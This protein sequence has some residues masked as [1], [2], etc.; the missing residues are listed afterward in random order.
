MADGSWNSK[1]Y[2]Q[3]VTHIATAVC[4]QHE[5][6]WQSSEIKPSL[7]RSR[8]LCGFSVR[9]ELTP[10]YPVFERTGTVGGDPVFG[11]RDKSQLTLPSTICVTMRSGSAIIL[12]GAWH[13]E[14]PSYSLHWQNK[15][16]IKRVVTYLIL[17]LKC[18]GLKS[19]AVSSHWTW[20][21]S[22]MNFSKEDHQSWAPS[23]HICGQRPVSFP[24]VFIPGIYLHFFTPLKRLIY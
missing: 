6:I 12:C 14:A 7:V 9:S 2:S 11:I 22:Y 21:P 8:C 17:T 13:S 20:G 1:I 23:L 19:S 24:P 18:H 5:S 10:R 4:H 16:L 3:L 15:V